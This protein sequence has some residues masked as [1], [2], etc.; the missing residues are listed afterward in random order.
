MARDPWTLRM[1]TRRSYLNRIKLKGEALARAR[2]WPSNDPGKVR[3]Q[4]WLSNFADSDAEIA[5]ALID[6]FVYFPAEQVNQLLCR[7]LT[8][9][10]Q[11]FGGTERS[12][13]HRKNRIT[14]QLSRT[15]FVPVEGERPSPADSG[16]YICRV[17]RQILELSDSNIATPAAAL[18]QYVSNNKTIVF[19]DDMVG[20]GN[21]MRGTWHREYGTTDPKSFRNAYQ[22]VRRECYCICLISSPVGRGSVRSLSGIDL[23]SAHDLQD[24]DRLHAALARIPDHPAGSGLQPAVDVLLEDYATR[25][26]LDSYMRNDRHPLLGFGNQGLTLG[27][28]HC[29]P[30]A[31]LPM[32]WAS[33]SGSWTPMSKRA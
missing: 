24:R 28:Q 4:S 7:T 12:C 3:S 25:L 23:I 30:D 11:N 10:F 20:T 27:F 21:Q 32:Y 2:I 33:G 13:E 5:A 8:R 1:A 26:I 17:V 19:V 15:L 16:N 31:T 14:K 6:V 29:M 22:R 18:T 9:L